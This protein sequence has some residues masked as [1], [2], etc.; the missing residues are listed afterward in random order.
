MGAY[1]PSK[2][3]LLACVELSSDSETMA[4]AIAGIEKT[5]VAHGVREKYD[6]V[7]Q[8]FKGV[9]TEK[10]EHETLVQASKNSNWAGKPPVSEA[11][12]REEKLLAHEADVTASDSAPQHHVDLAIEVNEA[13]EFHRNYTEAGKP[14][15]G[16]AV[17]AGDA[18]IHAWLEKEHAACEDMKIYETKDAEPQQVQP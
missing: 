8:Q 4:Y 18:L 3:E 10:K 15:S 12:H 17:E 16:E 2:D 7:V 1:L 14:A 6:G 11:Q 5:F 9:C 13:G